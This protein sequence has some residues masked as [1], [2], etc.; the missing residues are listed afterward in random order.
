MF[1]FTEPKNGTN[2]F[3]REWN[4]CKEGS[5]VSGILH[6][7]GG[8]M[9]VSQLPSD[10]D[11]GAAASF[12]THFLTIWVITPSGLRFKIDPSTR[13]YAGQPIPFR[14]PIE[15]LSEWIDSEVQRIGSK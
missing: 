8:D 6:C 4:N 10:A 2:E 9:T 3:C 5:T 12:S 15:L 13:G 7:H 14:S 11:I 1:Y